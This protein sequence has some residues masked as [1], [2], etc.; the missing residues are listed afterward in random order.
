MFSCHLS[1]E[2]GRIPENGQKDEEMRARE[3]KGIK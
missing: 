2:G 1:K 3:D